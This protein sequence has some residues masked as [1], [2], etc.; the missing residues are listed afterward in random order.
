MCDPCVAT[1]RCSRCSLCFLRVYLNTCGIAVALSIHSAA[2]NTSMRTLLTA[3]CSRPPQH[4]HRYL[5]HAWRYQQN[6]LKDEHKEPRPERTFNTEDFEYFHVKVCRTEQ[7]C[8]PFVVHCVLVVRL[9]V[10][11]PVTPHPHTACIVR[12]FSFHLVGPALCVLGRLF[13][14]QS[15]RVRCT[16][17][18]AICM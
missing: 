15:A 18:M 11:P 1:Y 6:R 12:L 8:M 17:A 14:S 10:P 4:R 7:A 2:S 16:L 9:F 5:E 13:E 3:F